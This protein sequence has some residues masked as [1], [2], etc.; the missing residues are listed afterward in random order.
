MAKL[1][2]LPN[3]PPTLRQRPPRITCSSCAAAK[4]QPAPHYPKT[5][6]YRVGAA[7]SSDICG[8]FN[9]TSR[10][11]NKY[12]LTVIDTR[13]RYL[14]VDFLQSR[15][16]TPHRLDV[17][18]TALK[19]R[20]GC[21]PRLFHTDNAKEYVSDSA[22]AVY[23]SHNVM[24]S[25]TVPHTPQQNGIAERIN[26]TLMNS[27]RAAPHHSSLPKTHWEDAVRDAAF[28]YNN[29]LHHGINTLPYTM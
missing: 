14:I 2:L 13:S 11:G 15:A 20:K 10:Q 3:L 7:F 24:H 6:N 18:L 8:P 21:K 25:T 29:I 26:S 4:Q 16:E 28:K 27:A 17:I 23:R 12:I 22:N 9:P 19:K 1:G 5:H